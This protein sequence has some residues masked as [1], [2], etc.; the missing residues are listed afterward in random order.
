IAGSWYIPLDKPN[1][2]GEQTVRLSI[3]QRGAE[4]AASILRI[5]GDTGAHSG[6]FRDGKW[7][8]SHYDGSRPAVISIT[9][10]SDGTLQLRERNDRA[11]AKPDERWGPVQVAYRPEAALAKGYKLPADHLA[12][13]STRET[14]QGFTFAFP[15][16][17]G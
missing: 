14:N 10:T 4:V 2:R 3:E 1:K 6:V 13:T 16:V 15:D 7:E 5:D 12:Y 9:P 17:D 11:D 8:L